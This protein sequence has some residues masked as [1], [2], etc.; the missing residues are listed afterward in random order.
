MATLF[1]Q[2]T[3]AYNDA[4]NQRYGARSAGH[5]IL[6]LIRHQPVILQRHYG[7]HRREA[8]GADRH[9]L[10]RRQVVAGSIPA[11]STRKNKDLAVPG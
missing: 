8:R 4:E 9:G 6:A 10:F 11:V 3:E 5:Q 2:K 7:A 1:R